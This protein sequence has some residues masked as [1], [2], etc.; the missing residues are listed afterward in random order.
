MTI[1]SSWAAIT[2]SEHPIATRAVGECVGELLDAGFHSPDLLI[3][4]ADRS[5]AGTMTEVATAFDVLVSPGVSVAFVSDQVMVSGHLL[6]SGSAMVAMAIRGFEGA[7]FT[8]PDGTSPQQAASEALAD[9]PDGFAPA[10]PT[11][12]I[13]VFDEWS[14]PHGRQRVALSP[15]GPVS[16]PAGWLV[17]GI[18]RPALHV[19]GVPTPSGG[20]LFESTGADPERSAGT[21]RHLHLDPIEPLS[22]VLGWGPDAPAAFGFVDPGHPGLDTT[23]TLDPL[24]VPTERESPGCSLAVG[25]RSRSLRAGLRHLY[26][27]GPQR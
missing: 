26:V 11:H 14:Q 20:I 10:G 23:G 7:P 13:V 4:A 22:A 19:N 24:D 3:V 17:G 6:R 2:H 12:A 8:I 25:A 5:F 16:E 27:F 18:R 1:A 15:P 9:L 21:I